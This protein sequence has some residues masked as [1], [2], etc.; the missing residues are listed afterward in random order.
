[1]SGERKR[2]ACLPASPWATA[3]G[4]EKSAWVVDYVDPLKGGKRR[5]KAFAKRKTPTPSLAKPA[6]KSAKGSTPPIAPASRSPR[7]GKGWLRACEGRDLQRATVEAYRQHL[8]PHI[9]PLLDA[10]N[11]SQLSAAMVR[12]F[13]KSLARGNCAVVAT[14]PRGARTDRLTPVR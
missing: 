4:A 10:V 2:R 8:R 5:L 14:W 13:E 6:A 1:M 11:L 9:E 12:D 7:L 3:E